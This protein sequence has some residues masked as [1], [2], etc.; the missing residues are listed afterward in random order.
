M[1][2]YSLDRAA[3]AAL[4]IISATAGFGAVTWSFEAN[5]NSSAGGTPSFYN[6]NGDGAPVSTF[7]APGGASSATAYKVTGTHVSGGFSGVNFEIKPGA[8][9]YNAVNATF[10]DFDAKRS[11]PTDITDWRVA[12]L[13]ATGY[14]NNGGDPITLTDTFQHFHMAITTNMRANG[15]NAGAADSLNTMVKV[16]FSPQANGTAGLVIDNLTIDGVEGSTYVPPAVSSFDVTFDGGTSATSSGSYPLIGFGDGGTQVGAVTA[17]YVSN[18][19]Q[20]SGTFTSGAGAA[21]W[22]VTVTLPFR[23]DALPVNLTGN[24]QATM[25]IEYTASKFNTGQDTSGNW[26]IRI[27]DTGGQNYLDY[28]PQMLLDGQPHFIPFNIFTHTNVSVKDPQFPAQNTQ[29]SLA[30]SLANAVNI[31]IL[32]EQASQS[33]STPSTSPAANSFTV[34][35]RLQIDRVRIATA[36]A[37]VNDWSIY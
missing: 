26:F 6:G 5:A 9:V 28:H 2:S 23:T 18:Q 30:P 21:F 11:A 29:G 13:G 37:G 15:A 22:F 35:P 19:L 10:I 3:L 17:N 33:G 32:T 1:F 36:L 8:A 12:F 34:T 7:V 31:T 24:N 14:S 25:G 27:E 20:T 16:I 4:C